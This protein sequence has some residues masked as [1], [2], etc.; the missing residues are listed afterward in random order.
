MPLCVPSACLLLAGHLLCA[1]S[2]AHAHTRPDEVAQGASIGRF[3]GDASLSD[4]AG[5][6]AEDIW[7]VGQQNVWDTWRN[8]GVIT[9]WDGVSWTDVAIRGDATGAGHLRS[10][11]AVSPDEVWVVGDGHDGLPYVAKGSAD[12][13]DRVNVPQFRV[14]DWLGGVAAS[15]G[16]VV[17]VGSR[18]G[19]AFLAVGGDTGGSW[20]VRS[21]PGGTMYGVALSGKSGG[22]AVGD[23]GAQ[24]LI[25][26]LSGSRWKPVDLPTI[27]GGFLRDVYVQSRDH[28]IA[29]G[30]VYT[31][32]DGEI[33]PLVLRWNGGKWTRERLRSAGKMPAGRK[34]PAG[35]AEL[36]GVTGDGH[37]R[38]W[39]SGYDPARP[40]EGLLLRR[41][42]SRWTVIRGQAPPREEKAATEERGEQGKRTVRLQAVAHVTDLTV[43][44][45]HVLDA[46][47][48]YS[49]LVERFG[50]PTG[51]T[52]RPERT[53]LA[54]G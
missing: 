9:H 12:G 48:R 21:G 4:V 15:P 47:G 17:A 35:R 52:D 6:S 44:V 31:G 13:F 8:H 29:V 2:V 23:S 45:G 7:A 36:Y 32:D 28:A 5:L 18:N 43:A 24:P 33:A 19:R 39:V 50:P 41:D 10:V 25:M 3:A 22:W 53:D 16:R 26:K 1:T 51:R 20:T 46:K 14:G 30:G 38:F 27:K 49:D 34:D 40:A 54:A 11:A 37:G 42:G